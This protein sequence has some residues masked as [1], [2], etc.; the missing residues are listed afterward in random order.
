ENA[1]VRPEHLAERLEHR[2]DV[3]ALVVCGQAD[4]G[5]H[6]R[7][8][9]TMAATLPQNTEV[10]DQLDLLADLLELEG[11]D[12]FRVLAY[13]RAATRIRETGSSIAQMALDGKAKELQGIGK[14]IEEKIVQIV[15]EGKIQALAKREGTI[16]DRKSTRLNSSH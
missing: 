8:I 15:E 1:V 12:T 2:P 10:A 6:L 4:A 9:A 16:P 3:P 7:I 14:T 5:A 13:R 11:Q